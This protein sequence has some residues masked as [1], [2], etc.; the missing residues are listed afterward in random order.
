MV[1]KQEKKARFSISIPSPLAR[2]I[3]EEAKK[4]RWSRVTMINFII[5]T[6][7]EIPKRENV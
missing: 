5:E 6:Y 1:K 2:K 7:F 3:D 4:N